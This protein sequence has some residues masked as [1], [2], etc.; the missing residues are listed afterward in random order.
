MV[1]ITK[2]FSEDEI[3]DRIEDLA[4]HIRSDHPEEEILFI[5][6]LK[7]A[8][9]FQADLMRNLNQPCRFDFLREKMEQDIVFFSGELDVCGKSVILLKDVVTTGVVENYLINQLRTMGPKSIKLA[10]LIDKPTDRKADI[11]VDYALFRADENI[12]VGYGMEY[13]G[14]YGNLPYIGMV[15]F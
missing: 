14:Q 15:E 5:G 1:T 13:K 4:Q 12:F 6:I 2:R 9:V 11:S 10:C 8:F 3:R 7:G